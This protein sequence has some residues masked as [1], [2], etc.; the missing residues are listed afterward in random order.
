MNSTQLGRD[1]AG[2]G[3]DERT[4]TPRR[5][6]ARRDT[7]RRQEPPVSSETQRILAEAQEYHRSRSRFPGMW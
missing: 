2:E 6:A 3:D 4:Q 5:K 1:G 7:E